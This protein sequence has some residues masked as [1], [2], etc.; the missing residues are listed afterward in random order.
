MLNFT[1]AGLVSPPS[2]Q[3]TL[4]KALSRMPRSR[5][6]EG[7]RQRACLRV[8]SGRFRDALVWCLSS[9]AQR[10]RRWLSSC[11]CRTL[12]SVVSSTSPRLSAV[13]AVCQ[14]VHEGERPEGKTPAATGVL[15][16]GPGRVCLLNCLQRVHG[17]G[18]CE[19]GTRV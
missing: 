9:D 19:T 7:W 18:E 14:G 17:L 12:L 3:Q 8:L 2:P 5:L 11:R 15:A 10:Q 13:S 6:G 1:A 4:Q 16:G